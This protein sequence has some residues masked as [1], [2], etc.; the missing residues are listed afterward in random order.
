M[1]EV[2][3]VRSLASTRRHRRLVGASMSGASPPGEI[4]SDEVTRSR[5][6]CAKC[7]GSQHGRMKSISGD[8]TMTRAAL[9]VLAAALA[10]ACGSPPTPTPTAEVSVRAA[11]RRKTVPR[12]RGLSGTIRREPASPRARGTG[13]GRYPAAIQRGTPGRTRTCGSADWKP[14]AP[15]RNRLAVD[16]G[17]PRKLPQKPFLRASG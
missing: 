4:G 9:V 14:S 1:H 7:R 13:D 5:T 16:G 17:D 15:S 8:L 10:C 2:V 3:V 11:F 12:S 6:G